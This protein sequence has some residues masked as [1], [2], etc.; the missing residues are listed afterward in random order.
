[1]HTQAQNLTG[2]YGIT[3]DLLTPPSMLLE[4]VR[5]ALQGGISILQY[6][7]KTSAKEAQQLQVEQ[8]LQLC[9]ANGVPLI[10]NDDVNLCR[11]SGADGVHLG[12]GDGIV[13]E[14]RTILGDSAII[15]VTC[16]DDIQRAQQAEQAGADYVAFGRFFSSQTKPEAS[17]ADVSL[18][19]EARERLGVPIVAIGGINAEN[20]ASLIA[21]GADMLAVIHSL[22]SGDDI[23]QNAQQ[24]VNLFE[25]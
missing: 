4:K 14:A 5:H 17:A 18:L 25:E 10:I 23:K 16:H 7:S 15:G 19:A 3:D 6:R 1:M 8:L 2:I 21:Q 20:G 13:D 11:A 22:F 9:R 24:L 12:K